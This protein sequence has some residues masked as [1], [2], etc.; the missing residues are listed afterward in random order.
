MGKVRIIDGFWKILGRSIR[1]SKEKT[2]FAPLQKND[3]LKRAIV[4]VI[5]DLVTDQRVNKTCSTLVSLGFDVLLVGR[6]KREI[7]RA[8]V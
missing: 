4:S 6:V 7:G 8:H 1:F 5:N 3:V 2:N